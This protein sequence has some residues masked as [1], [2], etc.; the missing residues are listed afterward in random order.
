MR[1]E[2]RRPPPWRVMRP[3]SRLRPSRIRRCRSRFRGRA[4]PPSA[5]RRPCSPSVPGAAGRRSFPSGCASSC[6]DRLSSQMRGGPA[7]RPAR[8]RCAVVRAASPSNCC[9]PC[10]PTVRFVCLR[11]E[12]ANDG[13][14]NP[15]PW[16]RP[17]SW[18]A[19]RP[20]R[21]ARCGAV[22]IR[23]PAGAS[24]RE[25]QRVVIVERLGWQEDDVSDPSLNDGAVEFVTADRPEQVCLA[26]T[27]RP[28]VSGA[29]TATIGRFEA[30]L[31][32]DRP[33][34]ATVKSGVRAL[35]WREPVRVPIDRRCWNGSS[36]CAF[37]T[38]S[39][40]NSTAPGTRHAAQRDAVPADRP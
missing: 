9:S 22:S 37:S 30:T 23:R 4:S 29:R 32:R 5:T 17:R 14:W 19:P 8:W 20:A 36:T 38:T 6:R 40:A 12:G 2:S 25:Q 18:R 35:D 16:H 26:V 27:A 34:D 10:C 39:I 13:R 28:V 24:T 11:P 1:R 21:R 31:V 33:S 7:S 3:A 15:T